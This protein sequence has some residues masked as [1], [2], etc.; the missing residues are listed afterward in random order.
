MIGKYITTVSPYIYVGYY[1]NNNCIFCSEADEYLEHLKE[2]SLPEIKKELKI[3]RKHYDFVNVM[4]R[5]PTIRSD[6]LE[7]LRFAQSLKFKQVGIT[8]N[9]RLLSIPSFAKAVLATGIHQI[10]ISLA[11]ASAT[12]HDKQTRVPGS[13]AQT[14]AGIKNVLRYKKQGVSLLIN[15]PMNKL[16]YKELKA[17]LKFL[18]D[19]GIKEINILNISPL[20]RRS[21]TKK[22]I[23]PMAQL[24][25][26]VF[27]TIKDNGYL[28]R[29]DIRILLVEFPP[30]SLPKEARK[31]FFPCLEKNNQKIRIPLCKNCPYKDKCDGILKDYLE[32]YGDFGLSLK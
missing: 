4:G 30:C 10:G 11:G 15:L 24:G 6:I 16:N 26:Y 12:I 31:Y 8:T 29:K 1:C 32:L 19:L 23:M 17:E 3:I 21:R 2:K 20:S 18:T 7:I 25:S 14:I 28:E 13:F 22:I 5:E 9:G 27:K